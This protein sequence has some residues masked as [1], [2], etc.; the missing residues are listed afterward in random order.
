MI[1]CVQ[2]FIV[3]YLLNKWGRRSLIKQGEAAY[4]FKTEKLKLKRRV[5]ENASE[6]FLKSKRIIHL[7]IK[8]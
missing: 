1:S 2:I 6:Y 5:L 8:E 4:L 7:N 3:T